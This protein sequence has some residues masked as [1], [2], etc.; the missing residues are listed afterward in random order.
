MNKVILVG[1]L[2]KEIEVR[3]TEKEIPVV[4]FTVAINRDY[5]NQNGE[6]ET[7]FINCIAFQQ[8]AKFMS[9]YL[10]K[11]DLIGVVGKIQTRNYEDEKG[12]HY[13]TEIIV[14]KVRALSKAKNEYENMSV[15]TERQQ[16]VEISPEELPF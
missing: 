3:Y 10:H 1:R 9:E 16:Q 7:D 14:E 15:K 2:T 4:N 5:K 12:K 8:S 13:I 6:Y 11:G